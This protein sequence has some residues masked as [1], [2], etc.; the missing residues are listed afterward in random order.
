[1]IDLSFRP[2]IGALLCLLIADA[3]AAADERDT[4]AKDVVSIFG[5]V[6]DRSAL[7]TAAGANVFL[8]KNPHCKVAFRTPEQ[9]ELLSEADVAS[10]WQAADAV[11]L[12]GV[13]GETIPRLE[14]LLTGAQP[15]RDDATLLALSGD[16]RLTPLSRIDGKSVFDGLD[17]DVVQSLTLNLSAS[18]DAAT[19]RQTLSDQYP[20]QAPWL[21][22]SAYRDARGPV[23]VAGLL[24]WT[25]A[26]HSGGIVVPPPRPQE[27]VRFMVG[28]Q[29]RGAGSLELNASRP[30]VAILDYDSSDRAGDRDVHE[31]IARALAG[32]DID[33]VSVLARWGEASVRSLTDLKNAPE[34][35]QLVAVLSLQ[36]FVIGGGE[37]REAATAALAALDVPVFKAIRMPDRTRSQWRLSSDG[38][39]WDTVHN[40]IAMP[41][42]QGVGQPHVVALA[43]KANLDEATGLRVAGVEPEETEVKRL[44]DR[45]SRWSLLRTKPNAQKRVAIVFYNHPPGRHNIGADN[46]DVPESLVELLGILDDA[47]YDL[48]TSYPTDG[49]RLLE[50]LQQT[51]VNLPNDVGALAAMHRSGISLDGE[52]YRSWFETL[53][54]IARRTIVAGPLARLESVVQSSLAGANVELARHRIETALGDTR[55]VLEGLDHPARDRALNLVKQLDAAYNGLLAGD[56]SQADAVSELTDA[57]TAS[58]IEGLSGWGEPP[59]NVMTWNDDLLVPGLEFGNVFVGPQPPRGWE[60]DEELLHANLTF[61]VHHQ[62]LGWYHYVRDVWEA[63]VVIH[64]GRHSTA[65]FLPG[66][67]NGL[68]AGDDPQLVLG[69]LPNAYIYIVDGVGEG[70]QAKRR[71]HAVIVDHLTPAMSTTPLYDELL[72]LRQLVESY[73][74][75]ESGRD[76]ATQKRAVERIR[77]VVDELNLRAELAASMR[78][79]LEVRGITFEQV[80]DELLVHEVGHYLTH[81][82]EDFMPLGLHVFGRDWSKEQVDTMLASMF[83]DSPPPESTRQA[84]RSSPGAERD[85][86]LAALDGRFIAP[87]KGNDPIRTPEVLPT[88]RN[89]HALGG[90]QTPT[91]LAWELGDQLA[92][93]A[94]AEETSSDE[95]EA[96]ILWASDTVRDEGA[97]VAFGLSLMGVEPVWNS[98]GIVRGIRRIEQPHRRDVT[99]V[100]SGLFRDLF[101]NQLVWL[102]RAW[103]VALDASSET[104]RTSEPGLIP[105]LDAALDRLDGQ[106]RSPGS[107]PIVSNEIAAHWL[108]ETRAQRGDDPDLAAIGYRASLRV[109]GNAPGG[110]GAGINRLAERSGSWDTRAELADAWRLRMG[111][112]YGAGID[113]LPAHDAFENRLARTERTFLGRAS[114]LYGLLDNNDAFDY[115]GGLSLAVEASRGTAPKSRV[116]SHADPTA[117]RMAPLESELLSELRGRELNPAWIAALMD[118][119]YAGARTMG[120]E[121]MENL[122]GW[123]VTNPEVVKPWVWDEVKHIYVDDGHEL[124]LDKFLEQGSNVHVKANM[125]AIMLVAVQKDFWKPSDVVVRDLARQFAEIASEHGLPGSGHTRPDHPVMDLVLANVSPELAESL[126]PVLDSARRNAPKE[127]AP[128]AMIAEVD[129]AAQAESPSGVAN[130]SLVLIIGG[131]FLSLILAG[132]AVGRSRS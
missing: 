51:A 64:V 119:G 6:S 80:D 123:Q 40:R 89:F 20:A 4:G 12:L 105:A 45:I 36:D 39:A 103:L 47:G 121:F 102:D 21:Q 108:R 73:E 78:G 33:T 44:A 67:R 84:L 46:L 75:A 118:H 9:I 27:S 17:E 59:G 107:E 83:G 88:G 110:Y 38:V 127:P 16:P 109:F 32:H 34:A 99:F 14:R 55:H 129:V 116:I 10:L 54:M 106:W 82:Q 94:L 66:K 22:A 28:G 15:P 30:F 97:M 113:G 72:E 19:A 120:S 61:P 132:I 70:I 58:G 3:F 65:E 81:L 112:A 122:W 77:I 111:H 23:N 130:R 74:A 42:L 68:S 57:L 101:P 62:Y 71:G 96:V 95:A 60:I 124:G 53:P 29:S 90:E 1:M 69:D 128:P 43:G 117:V 92:K 49:E 91:R 8:Q 11:L 26:R 25:A 86:L 56:N 35:E 93:Q 13:F 63:D 114:N 76:S 31:S 5:I 48:G 24:A 131:V 115:L 104:I 98:R 50:Q 41:E 100:T 85:A 126:R 7:E 87:G 52:A 37:G 2:L 18:Q 79:E 125:L